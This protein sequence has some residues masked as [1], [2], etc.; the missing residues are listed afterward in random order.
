M[1]MTIEELLKSML[2]LTPEERKKGVSDRFLTNNT[3]T[4]KRIGQRDD[5]AELN[6][7][8]EEE[9]SNWI[10]DWTSSN[11]YNNI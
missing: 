4:W 9:K 11:P 1:A 3:E 8:S 10:N 7:S 5:F 6:F 2:T